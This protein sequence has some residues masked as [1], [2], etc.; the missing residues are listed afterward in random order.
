M[1]AR[2]SVFPIIIVTA[3]SLA[4]CGPKPGQPLVTYTTA[5][6]TIPPSITADKDGPYALYPDDGI[7]PIARIDLHK[8]DPLGFKRAENGHIVGFARDKEYDLTAIL[9][10]DYSWK[11]VENNSAEKK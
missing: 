4:G 7:S 11:F 5:T 6:I 3:I 10:L 2:R 9:A 8:G 1:S